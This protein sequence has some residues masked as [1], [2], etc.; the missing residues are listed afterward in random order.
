MRKTFLHIERK[1][2]A[3]FLAK[4]AIIV[5]NKLIKCRG[6]IEAPFLFSHDQSLEGKDVKKCPHC[7][8]RRGVIKENCIRFSYTH[9]P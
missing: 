8:R 6:N 5:R 7:C 2:G 4:R 1:G 9:T 3:I